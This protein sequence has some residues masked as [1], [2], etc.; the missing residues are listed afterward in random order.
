[1]GTQV[2]DGPTCA[3]AAV[4]GG[5]RSHQHPLLR[6]PHPFTTT[7]HPCTTTLCGCTRPGG[8]TQVLGTATHTERSS[9]AQTSAADHIL[10]PGKPA[11]SGSTSPATQRMPCMAPCHARSPPSRRPAPRL[12][13][14]G[15][16]PYLQPLHALRP[17]L[18]LK[19]LR[20][21]LQQGRGGWWQPDGAR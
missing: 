19:E 10:K 7:V 2:L 9:G 11:V 4:A 18:L 21:Q 1:M 15:V 3:Q 17:Q 5:G 20:P 16:S 6:L 8:I 14:G 12:L 13:R